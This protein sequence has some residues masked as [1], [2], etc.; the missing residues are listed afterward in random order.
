MA[1]TPTNSAPL[2]P[3]WA[4]EQMRYARAHAMLALP[5]AA[6]RAKGST[7]AD[8]LVDMQ[9]GV[10]V[11]PITGI[12]TRHASF[13]TRYFGGAGTMDVEA[14]VSQAAADP[15]V[16]AILLRIDSPGGSVSGVAELAD[17]V[18]A[19]AVTKPV[20]AQVEGIAAS[21][22]YHVASQ[23]TKIFAGR[24]D[25]IGSIGVQMMLYDFSKQF[26]SEGIEAVPINTGEFK[27]AGAM[28]TK[29]TDSQRDYF[30][31]LVDGYFEDFEAAVRRGRGMSA[32][33]WEAVSDAQIFL[34]PEAMVHGLIDGIQ[35]FDQ[36]L[37]ALQAFGNTGDNPRSTKAMTET[38]QVQEAPAPAGPVAATLA[39]I[40]A[41][42]PGADNDFLVAQLKQDA[43]VAQAQIA[44]MA[45]QNKRIEAVKAEAAEAKAKAEAPGVE[46]LGNGGSAKTETFADPQA[47]WDAA[48]K[49]EMESGKSRMKA[50]IAAG[51]KHPELRQALVDAVNV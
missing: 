51:M 32:K 6:V 45:E 48:V 7:A 12:M 31:G 27:S 28:G 16:N 21:A 2:D 17:A 23:C 4:V 29:I 24:M 5:E 40:Q 18:R 46:P 47:E 25:V 10:A 13:W 1:K 19:A 11:I 14:A 43:T 15:R 22:A 20:H 26:E 38:T 37:A 30:Q 9:G 41:A 42:C 34:A 44:W 36:T 33:A 39:E 3:I 35:T 50:V 8:D 49:T